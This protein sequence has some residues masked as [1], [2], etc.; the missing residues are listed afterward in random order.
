MQRKNQIK[1]SPPIK[2]IDFI[3]NGKTQLQGEY[4]YQKERKM[5]KCFYV[6]LSGIFLVSGCF[7]SGPTEVGKQSQAAWSSIVKERCRGYGDTPRE[8]AALPEPQGTT[9]EPG[10]I[11][12]YYNG[13]SHEVKECKDFS[14]QFDDPRMIPLLWGS[15]EQKT[16]SEAGLSLDADPGLLG[17]AADLEASAGYRRIDSYDI[18]FGAVVLHVSDADPNSDLTGYVSDSCKAEINR[19]S[20]IVNNQGENLLHKTY[21]MTAAYEAKEI[22]YT[23]KLNPQVF[24]D[25]YSDEEVPDPTSDDVAD[26]IKKCG[27][28]TR[29]GGKLLKFFGI[30]LSGNNCVTGETKI[31][32]NRPYF[33]ATSAV[34]LAD[35]QPSG[36]L[37]GRE[38]T[39]QQVI[40]DEIEELSDD[41]ARALGLIE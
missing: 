40:V 29:L 1:I 13:I 41:E 9:I 28:Y 21:L 23:F 10:K 12:S 20:L 30:D 35:L 37:S 22:S 6:G 5:K 24:D 36:A 19:R 16:R 17:S 7:Q 14:S 26:Y 4:S 33:I 11:Y 15:I 27:P 34:S 18:D 32:A 39:V 2:K 25:F 31:T 8:C 38:F 3:A